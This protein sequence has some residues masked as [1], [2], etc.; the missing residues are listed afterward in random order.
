MRTL[1]IEDDRM[2][3]N[4]LTK[5][6]QRAGLVADWVRDGVSGDAALT[7]GG[8]VAVLLDLG[9][10]RRT[11]FEVLAAARARGDRTPILILTARDAVADRVAGLD[12]GADD[13]IVKPFELSELLARL[14]AA[15]RRSD[16]H[17][18]SVVGTEALQLDLRTR[19]VIYRNTRAPLSAREFAL[20]HALVEHPGAILSRQQLEERIYGWDDA[21]AS[22]AVEVIIHGLR[23]R[24]GAGLIRNVRGLGWKV[25]KSG[26]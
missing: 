26:P 17:A 8:Y 20:L 21:V 14:R 25:P 22:N 9:L 7:A 11:G 19:E 2:I 12:L 13:Y 24:F 16:G 15:I 18:Q 23:R 5:A 1:L 6:L 3:G 4:S 10:P